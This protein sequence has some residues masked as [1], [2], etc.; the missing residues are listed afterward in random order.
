METKGSHTFSRNKNAPNPRKLAT[1]LKKAHKTEEQKPGASEINP[2]DRTWL[3][4][5]SPVSEAALEFASQSQTTAFSPYSGDFFFHL[6]QLK[7]AFSL[8][9]LSDLLFVLE[10][11]YP[12]LFPK[13]GTVLEESTAEVLVA[14]YTNQILTV[15]DSTEFE[16][17]VEKISR[18]FER[19]IIIYWTL[20]VIPMEVDFFPPVSGISTSLWRPKTVTDYAELYLTALEEVTGMFRVVTFDTLKRNTILTMKDGFYG[21]S[22]HEGQQHILVTFNNERT[23]AKT[24]YAIRPPFIDIMQDEYQYM[25]ANAR[26]RHRT[27][28][29][30]T[31]TS[32][33]VSSSLTKETEAILE[34]VRKGSMPTNPEQLVESIEKERKNLNLL[35]TKAHL[36]KLASNSNSSESYQWVQQKLASLDAAADI[37]H[38]VATSLQKHFSRV[39]PSSS[40]AVDDEDRVIPMVVQ[41][42]GMIHGAGPENA[43]R[44]K[45]ECNRVAQEKMLARNVRTLQS[46]NNEYKKETSVLREELVSMIQNQAK[47]DYQI[48]SRQIE[49]QFMKKKLQETVKERDRTKATVDKYDEMI[50]DLKGSVETLLRQTNAGEEERRRLLELFTR[51]SFKNDHSLDC[52]YESG[53]NRRSLLEFLKIILGKG[54]FGLQREKEK[55]DLG[56]AFDKMLDEQGV[57][58]LPFFTAVQNKAILDSRN[59]WLPYDWMHDRPLEKKMNDSGEMVDAAGRQAV[60]NTPELFILDVNPKTAE[61]TQKIAK[62]VQGADGMPVLDSVLQRTFLNVQF[63]AQGSV[64]ESV[65]APLREKWHHLTGRL[66]HLSGESFTK[67]GQ[68]VGARVSTAS[69]KSL[70]V[71]FATQYL[72]RHGY[73]RR[74]P[75]LVAS[76]LEKTALS[77]DIDCFSPHEKLVST[78]VERKLRKIVCS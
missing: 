78:F 10:R 39:Q 14:E 32:I 72:P 62:A 49:L 48:K 21:C 30:M 57:F 67:N 66:L 33:V 2:V 54:N 68:R 50:S 35:E 29:K 64:E 26:H 12:E 19:A 15:M 76:V 9:I 5:P 63:P 51:T 65:N 25:F 42:R 77:E 24:G 53:R 23:L 1:V 20:G 4:H 40:T 61:E 27:L 46:E 58:V 6:I 56:I 36:V 28:E 7:T 37:H 71:P 75:A 60:T 44:A 3:I 47:L 11:L 38:T 8:F 22:D 34:S 55:V 52:N 69:I 59:Y 45:I 74:L 41:P 13:Y 18:E 31:K 73:I 16:S 17:R 70:V 43:K